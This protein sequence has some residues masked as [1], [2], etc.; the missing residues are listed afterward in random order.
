MC[1]KNDCYPN[2]ALL[3]DADVGSADLRTLLLM[4]LY[5]YQPAL[6]QEW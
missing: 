5:R 1:H 6:F 3:T 2:I 4:F